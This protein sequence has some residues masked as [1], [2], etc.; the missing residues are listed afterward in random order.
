MTTS[1]H[2]YVERQK[3]RDLIQISN[4][5]LISDIKTIQKVIYDKTGFDVSLQNVVSHLVKKYMEE[6]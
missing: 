3:N 2:N 4:P 6:K 5:Q 1:K